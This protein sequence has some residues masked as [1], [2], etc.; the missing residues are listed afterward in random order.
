[1]VIIWHIFCTSLLSVSNQMYLNVDV[2]RSKHTVYE[3]CVDTRVM[4]ECSEKSGGW[5]NDESGFE[6]R[7]GQER[8]HTVWVPPTHLAQKV[9]V[10]ALMPHDVPVQSP[11]GGGDKAATHLGS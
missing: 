3:H 8:V 9:K 2:T 1:M 10:N 4:E 6:S 7:Q 11:R 5:K